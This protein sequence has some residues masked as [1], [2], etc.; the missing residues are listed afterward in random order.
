[1][2][3]V[4]SKVRLYDLAK[5]LK[6]DHKRLV[7]D[8]RREGVDV[9]VPSNRISKE[10]ADKIRDKYFPKKNAPLGK[11]TDV[12]KR[13]Y[14]CRICGAVCRSE[15]ALD[16]HFLD[17]HAEEAFSEAVTK[18]GL[19]R[20]NLKSFVELQ[21][22][23]FGELRWF[24]DACLRGWRD[25]L[26]REYQQPAATDPETLFEQAR[27]LESKITAEF[28]GKRLNVRRNVVAR[29][30]EDIKT[31]RSKIPARKV[32]WK[33]LP[34]GKAPF[35]KIIERFR[36]LSRENTGAV[37][38]MDRL[39]RIYSLK[40]S[41]TFMGIDEFQGYVAFRFGTKT[42]LDCPI[43]GN[44]IYVF[45]E[46][47]KTLSRLTKSELLTGRRR[48]VERIVHKGDWFARLKASLKR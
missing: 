7:E 17:S 39:D 24:I 1:M 44:A 31:Y 36:H 19:E 40:P 6:I 27:I 26:S 38:D 42:A 45:G 37:Y 33:L 47:W 41:E 9:S 48:D 10:L 21:R 34:P 29:I 8:V 12:E 20:V 3:A 30:V 46:N 35:S 28:R 43:I 15:S 23:S 16:N 4:T 5:E 14:A 18:L 13:V 32:Q 11:G 22:K 2:G 25:I